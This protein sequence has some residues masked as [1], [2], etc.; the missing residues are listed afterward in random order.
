MTC[1]TIMH[2]N[3]VTVLASQTV[4]TAIGVLDKNTFRSVPV[5][6]GSGRMIGQFGVHAVLR[7]LVPR[8]ATMKMGLPHLPFVK[9]DLDDLKRRLR[10]FWDK[11]VGDYVDRDAYVVHL[12]TPLTKTVLALYHTHDNLPVVDRASGRLVGIISYWDVVRSLLR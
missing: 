3:P 8:I 6:D 2:P 12:D 11:P 7:M 10:V 4:G 9:D 1:A 5:T